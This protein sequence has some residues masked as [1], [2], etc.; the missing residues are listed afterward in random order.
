[1]FKMELGPVMEDHGKDRTSSLPVNWTWAPPEVP[2][3]LPALGLWI[4]TFHI[5]APRLF[6]GH[7]LVIMW[8]WAATWYT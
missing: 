8:Y 1:M 5:P 7:N 4:P 2:Y 6:Q 3:H